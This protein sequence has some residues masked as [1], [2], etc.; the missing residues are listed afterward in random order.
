M[1]VGTLSFYQH[2]KTLFSPCGSPW[3]FDLF[4]SLWVVS[5][6]QLFDALFAAPWVFL[7]ALLLLIGLFWSPLHSW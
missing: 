4:A 6:A 3:H 7:G 5:L 1:V 2:L